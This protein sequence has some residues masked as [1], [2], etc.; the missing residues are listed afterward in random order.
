M[1]AQLHRANANG[2]TALLSEAAIARISS[3]SMRRSMATI[4]AR[5]PEVSEEEL[6]AMG[7]WGTA[8]VAR[9]YVERADVFSGRNHS[10]LLFGARAICSES[11]SAPRVSGSTSESA[12]VNGRKPHK[13]KV[14]TVAEQQA[15]D[16]Q[17]RKCCGSVDVPNP[18]RRK[19]VEANAE[20]FSKLI[21][22][23]HL[24][25]MEVRDTL[26][27]LGIHC[28]KRDVEGWRQPWRRDC[29]AAAAAALVPCV[30]LPGGLPPSLPAS[31]PESGSEMEDEDGSGEGGGG[32]GCDVVILGDGEGGGAKDGGGLGRVKG[33]SGEGG[34]GEGG[35][36]EGGGGDS[37][38]GEGSVAG[39]GEVL[40]IS[41]D[42]F[43][44][45]AFCVLD[46][47]ATHLARAGCGGGRGLHSEPGQ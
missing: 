10:E 32:D 19:L 37:D 7:E 22:M 14:L 40:S 42:D 8:E 17:V 46:E 26:C 6:V 25:T 30:V 36:C 31:P 47:E 33:G 28:S 9:L 43:D 5:N 38:K 29:K 39:E 16:E 34:V 23:D 4:L 18:M 2:K 20:L 21:S 1:R 27:S 3:K 44:D 45:K 35:G 12:G 15:K 11:Q 41:A 13:S 24:P